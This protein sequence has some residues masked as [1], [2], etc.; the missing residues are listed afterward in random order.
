MGY[1]K[2]SNEE[3]MQIVEEYRQGTPVNKLMA[4]YGYATKKSI[5]DKVKFI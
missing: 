5:T 1:K 2:L 3:E 4:K